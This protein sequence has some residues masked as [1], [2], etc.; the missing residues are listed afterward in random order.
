MNIR[1]LSKVQTTSLAAI[2][3]ILIFT[4]IHFA[5][6]KVTEFGTEV[7]KKLSMI[8]ENYDVFNALV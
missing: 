1:Q 3:N 7:E 6:D 4:K 5:Y 2:T 8:G